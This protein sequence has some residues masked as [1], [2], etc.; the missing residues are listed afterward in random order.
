[1]A[2]LQMRTALV[3]FCL[4][5]VSHAMS[6]PETREKNPDA[7]LGTMELITKWGYPAEAHTVQTED[8]YLLTVHRIPHGKGMDKATKGSIMVQHGLLCSSAD[9]IYTGPEKS[10]AFILADAGYDVWLGNARGNTY[11]K[12]HVSLSNSD[13]DFWKFSWHEMG[14]YDLPAVID[15]II[16]KTGVEK[17]YYAGHSQ[18]TTMFYVMGSERPEYNDK[19]R[20]MFSLAPVAYM[21]NMKSPIFK[22]LAPFSSQL[23]WALNLIG[24]YEFLP[25]TELFSAIGQLACNDEAITQ[26]ICSNVL[27][28]IGGYNSE[29]LNRTILP[30]ILGH[31]PAGAS[32]RQLVH[33]AQGIV[34]GNFRQYDFGSITNLFKYGSLK[35]PAYDLSKVTAPVALHYSDNDWL[36]A[37]VDVKQLY[38][39]LKNPIGLFRVPLAAFNHLDYMWATDAPTLVYNTAGRM[40]GRIRHYLRRLR[41]CFRGFIAENSGRPLIRSQQLLTVNQLTSDWNDPKINKL[42][43]Y[44]SAIRATITVTLTRSTRAPCGQLENYTAAEAG[45]VL[46]FTSN[47]HT[48]ADV[49][50]I[51]QLGDCV[52]TMILIVVLLQLAAAT[53]I[54]H[55]EDTPFNPDVYLTTPQIIRRHGYPA[56]SHT[57]ETEDGYL[58]TL[59]RIPHG[60]YRKY[61]SSRIPVFLQHGLLAASD[62]WTTNGPNKSLAYILSDLGYDVWLG[63]ARGN[64]YSRGHVSL[65]I[66]DP[67]YWNFSFHEMGIYDLPAAI[68][69][70]LNVTGHKT[71]FYIGHSMGTTMFYVMASTRPEYNSKI[72]LMVS[73]APV[74]FVGHVK[75]PIRLLVP[76]RNDLEFIS[77]YLGDG[78]FLPHNKILDWISKYGCEIITTEE[79]I[80][81][82]WIFVLSGFDP[83]QFNMTLLPVILGHNP[84]GTSTKTII[85]YAQEIHS[86]KFQH[87]DEGTKDDYM[88]EEPQVYDLSKI[89][90][91]IDLHYADNDWLASPIDVMH[92]ANK[93]SNE[94]GL[95][96][97]PFEKFNHVDF[98]WAKNAYVL[99]YKKVLEVLEKYEPTDDNVKAKE[100]EKM[101]KKGRMV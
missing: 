56:E 15:Y 26:E 37:V 94:V 79:K 21:S 84:A 36:A 78:E 96:K 48:E 93:L 77:K 64:T 31:T 42:K 23:Q 75:S 25:Q 17:I 59:H 81:E 63:N 22:L 7:D 70:V 60:K 92:L 65:S 27:F 89:S 71:L 62:C 99:A 5:A 90:V 44:P 73:L 80:C 100:A 30:L 8:G 74:A 49:T 54:R 13:D 24:V 87:F 66:S 57:I 38:K 43:L 32:T 68:D 76:F 6:V 9:W 29:Q 47:V 72:Q 55:T 69:F 82:E 16:G 35:A 18:G 51:F 46:N 88:N 10:F 33:Y 58:L 2:T 98:I 12:S 19:I 50:V 83:A 52:V 20:A 28:L 61:N 67:K 91:P 53:G 95:N 86:G 41:S 11:S 85:H 3:V 101:K 45:T 4:M 1:M 97:I 34:S 40:F 39:E 14:K